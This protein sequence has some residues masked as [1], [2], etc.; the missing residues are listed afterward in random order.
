MVLSRRL[1]KSFISIIV[2]TEDLRG[3]SMVSLGDDYA[4]SCYVRGTTS[5]ITLRGDG[6]RLNL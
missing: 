4:R 3:L 1:A 6:V 2:P 5:E